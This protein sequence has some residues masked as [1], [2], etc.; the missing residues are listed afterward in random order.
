MKRQ[1]SFPQNHWNWPV[2]LT[3]KH[4][5]RVGQMIYTGGQVDLDES[6]N[7][8]NPDDLTQQCYNSLDYLS[9]VL[10]DL[11]A[12]IDDLVK[13][14]IYF[15]GDIAAESEILKQIE[16]R[17]NSQTRPVVNTVC[18][19]ELCYPDMLVEIEGVAM[20]DKDGSR[21]PRKCYRLDSLPFISPKFSHAIHCGDMIFTSDLSAI[22]PTG[23]I[24]ATDDLISQSEIMMEQMQTLLNAVGVGTSDV[25][26]LNVFYV[27]QDSAQQWEGAAKIRAG[28]FKDPGP[29]AT[30]VPVDY[31]P[32]AGQM[33]KISA[34]AM[35]GSCGNH[36]DKKYAWPKGHWDWTAPLPYKH[37]NLCRGMIHLG[38]QVSLD[39]SANV[40]DPDDM[41]AQTKRSMDNIA[42]V[43]SEFGATLD[44]VVKVT[45]FY[46]GQASA[47]ALHQNLMIRSNSYCEPGPATTGIPVRNLVYPSMIIE[48]EVIAMIDNDFD[49]KKTY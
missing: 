25:L 8:R 42:K 29:A 5:V 6:G 43:L 31:F 10:E 17:L 33:T 24:E 47:Q 4:G 7:V 14:V 9:V 35:F 40:I 12:D 38:G 36:L 3:H 22:S 39:S 15:V 19:P 46:Q 2:K 32:I 21:L 41:I 49:W 30:G 11:G 44:D 45:T 37:G 23:A 34:T 13:L 20:R 1:Y 26:K 28:F 48:I 27:G 18:L 16:N